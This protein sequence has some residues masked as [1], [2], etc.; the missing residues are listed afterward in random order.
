MTPCDQKQY[1]ALT[2][3]PFAAISEWYGNSYLAGNT[4]FWIRTTPDAQFRC[5]VTLTGEPARAPQQ[6][7]MFLLA[8]VALLQAMPESGLE[9]SWRALNEI[10]EHHTYRPLALLA[11][12]A[13]AQ[14]RAK[15]KPTV[16]QHSFRIADE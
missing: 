12:P 14:I 2:G 4:G 16:R 1:S 11:A 8:A 9:E 3:E 6:A 15:L 5:A 10:F 7:T 13:L